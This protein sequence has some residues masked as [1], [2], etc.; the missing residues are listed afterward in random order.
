MKAR[1]HAKLSVL[2]EIN[3]EG[4]KLCHECRVYITL[5]REHCNLC[6]VCIDNIDHHCVF[7]SK[8]IG[9]GNKRSFLMSLFAFV[10]NLTYFVTVQG[11]LMLN[12]NKEH[13]L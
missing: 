10:L 1:P 2:P 11:A 8:C 7:Y 6:N 4:Y 9:G 5:N 3:A 12:K 13:T